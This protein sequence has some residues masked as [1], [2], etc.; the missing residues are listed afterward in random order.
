MNKRLLGNTG[1]EVGEIGLGAWQ[2][3][4]GA[5]GMVNRETAFAMI[6]K[7]LDL[8]A[9]FIDTAPGYG[10]G[11]SEELL[12]EALKGRRD[13]AVICTKFGHHADGTT[14]YS[15][16][17]LRSSVEGSL[18]RLRTDYLDVLLLHNPPSELHDGSKAPHYAE[19]ELLQTEG[20]IRAYG[21]SV[22]WRIDLETVLQT[23]Q[24]KAIEALFNAF[25]QDPLPAFAQAAA[26]GVGLI[27][28][29]PLDSGW[30]SGKYDAQ[31]TFDDVR[32]RWTTQQIARR[33][34]LVEKFSELVPENTSIKDAALQYILAQPQ[35]STIIPGARSV[36][37]VEEN[38]AATNG[39]L[40]DS[41]VEQM[42]ALWQSEIEDS[43]LPW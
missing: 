1:I 18:R 6:D 4:G 10:E 24:A 9:N 39:R 40:P 32:S 3:G 12:G 26:Q 11:K 36:A 8:G 31:S 13:R 19:L 20:K 42:H 28:K 41:V 35:V 23:T 37:Q 7:S 34:R 2:I 14:N 38:C 5:W 21:V 25:H 29:V 27:I 16:D 43:P 15:V 33:G 22:D 30:L 17:K